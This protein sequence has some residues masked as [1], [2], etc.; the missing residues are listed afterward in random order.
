MTNLRSMTG[1]ELQWVRPGAFKRHYELRSGD[2]VVGELGFERSV[3]WTASGKTGEGTWNFDRSGFLRSRITVRDTASTNEV[4]A[5]S[6]KFVRRKEEIL[7]PD[8]SSYAI[9]VNG[10]RSRFTLETPTGETLAVV[11]RRGFFRVVW[12]VEVRY[13]A[14]SIPELPWL[15][16]LVWYYILILR[17]R[18][19]RG[20]G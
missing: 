5:F 13:K 12:H 6:E 8:G 17:S 18:A 15:V 7:L 11:Q 16:L 20:H 9:G 2:T 19:R 4:G 3:G 10:F 14:K 1:R